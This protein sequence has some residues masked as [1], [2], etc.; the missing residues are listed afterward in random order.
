MLS[1]F[2]S[3]FCFSLLCFH[4]FS[5]FLLGVSLPGQARVYDEAGLR[6]QVLVFS[7]NDAVR[8]PP[9]GFG[10]SRGC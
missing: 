9:A 2:R 8:L 5:F 3:S 1:L 7:A 4:L 6:F 10:P